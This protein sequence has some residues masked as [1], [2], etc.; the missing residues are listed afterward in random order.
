M[1]SVEPLTFSGSQRPCSLG[2]GQFRSRCL[3]GTC[4]PTSARSRGS[5]D[6]CREGHGQMGV[7][8]DGAGNKLRVVHY[9]TIWMMAITQNNWYLIIYK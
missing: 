6:R 5:G 2:L 7:H 3:L 4:G 1:L 8:S 9:F